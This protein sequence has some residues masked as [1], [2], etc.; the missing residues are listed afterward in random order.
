MSDLEFVECCTC[1][2]KPGTPVLCESCLHNR[3]AIYELTSKVETLPV[4]KRGDRISLGSEWWWWDGNN[5]YR[6]LV[7][8]LRHRQ[9]IVGI[10]SDG[11][12]FDLGIDQL[13]KEKPEPKEK[14]KLEEIRKLR[15]K[16]NQLKEEMETRVDC[17]REQLAELCLIDFP[18]IYTT[19]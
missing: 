17:L 13:F 19:K 4:N 2:A 14:E 12:R 7:M 18:P 16:I 6:V 5:C 8:E 11:V 3:H 10:L 1:K 15:E 9:N